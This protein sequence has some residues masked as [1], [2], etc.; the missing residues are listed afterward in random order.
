VA[1]LYIADDDFDIRKNDLELYY[2]HAPV[3]IKKS[4]KETVDILM[5]QPSLEV[6]R[7]LPAL[8]PPR[9]VSVS[10]SQ[11]IVRYLQFAVVELRV[12][13]AA[14]HNALLNYH[15]TSPD[16]DESA[17]LHFLSSSPNDPQ[18]ARPLYDLDYALRVCK[19]NK[20][21][22]ACIHIYSE[23]VL[24]ESS[25]DLALQN[26]DIELAKINADKPVDDDLLRK[27]LWLKVAR[28][29]VHDKQDIKT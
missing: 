25:V 13:D 4:P 2:R 21:L 10:V 16:P 8:L 18:T 6:R 29:V 20:R 12:A 23:M 1:L 28:H 7:L 22:Q 17:L 26:G 9:P 14:V 11:Q 19:A 24:Y 27:K 15:A 5:R 3:L